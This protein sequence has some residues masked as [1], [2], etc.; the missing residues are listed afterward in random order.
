MTYL[1]RIMILA[2]FL[3]G[4]SAFEQKIGAYKTELQGQ[5][6]D[7]LCCIPDT[8]FPHSCDGWLLCDNPIMLK[9]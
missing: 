8:E 4:C 5:S 2:L 6:D 3:S 9:E 7:Q 1:F